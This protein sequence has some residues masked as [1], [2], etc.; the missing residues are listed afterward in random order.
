MYDSFVSIFISVKVLVSADT[1]C[2]FLSVKMFIRNFHLL[3]FCLSCFYI[4]IDCF[5]N[6]IQYQVP[7]TKSYHRHH[8]GLGSPVKPPGYHLPDAKWF[9]QV[10]WIIFKSLRYKQ[11]IYSNLNRLW[12]TSSQPMTEPGNND[13][14][15]T[16]LS[17][18]PVIF[19]F[20]KTLS[21]LLNTI[22]YDLKIFEILS[23]TQK[24]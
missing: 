8:H 7:P 13:F 18:N 11:L 15:S 24:C 17:G 12:T 4:K 20:V 23:V 10:Q 14:G 21:G 3:S 1:S 6:E 9:N 2:N 19:I 5:S 16:T 22:N